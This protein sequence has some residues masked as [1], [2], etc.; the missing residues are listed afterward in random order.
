MSP[1]K[2]PSDLEI[3]YSSFAYAIVHRAYSIISLRHF[4]G[5]KTKDVTGVIRISRGSGYYAA[6]KDSSS[7]TSD[8]EESTNTQLEMLYFVNDSGVRFFHKG[9]F[10]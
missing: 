4:P 8:H 9:T 7:D 1:K 6:K 2:R 5:G 10:F 3:N